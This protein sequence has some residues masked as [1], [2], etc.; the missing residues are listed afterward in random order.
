MIVLLF[1]L[2]NLYNLVFLGDQVILL[3]PQG[4]RLRG[5]YMLSGT[6]NLCGMVLSIHNSIPDMNMNSL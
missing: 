5:M 1:T 6:P 2:V 3:R 4:S